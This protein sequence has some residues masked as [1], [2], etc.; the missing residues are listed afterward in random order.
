ML[1][2]RRAAGILSFV[3]VLLAAC[4]APGTGAGGSESQPAGS[5]D[6]NT[7]SSA[8]PSG[9]APAMAEEGSVG[10][11][12]IGVLAADPSAFEGQEIR[13]LARVDHVLVDGVA[14]LTSPSA[15]DEGQLAVVIRPDAQ[16]DKEIA[17][18]GVVWVEGSVVGFSQEDLDGAGVDVSLDELG[19]FSGEFAIVAD[20]IGDPLASDTAS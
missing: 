14:F 5:G 10:R 13:V 12:D 7:S 1:R 18:G 4:A 8:A 2:M 3:V 19:D 20:A 6:V 15:T 16:V 9:S 17:E 11:V